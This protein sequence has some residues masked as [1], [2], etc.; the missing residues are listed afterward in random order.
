MDFSEFVAETVSKHVD[1]LKVMFYSCFQDWW[2]ALFKLFVANG[3]TTS[4][5]TLF[6]LIYEFKMIFP[7]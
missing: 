4:R 7:F 5:D 1:R 3:V 2:Y 6:E